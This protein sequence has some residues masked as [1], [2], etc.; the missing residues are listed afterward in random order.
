MRGLPAIVN[1]VVTRLV[2]GYVGLSIATGFA[3]LPSPHAFM[4]ENAPDGIVRRVRACPF[5]DQD[6]DDATLTIRSIP[7]FVLSSV[8]A[9]N[10]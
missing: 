4:N 6:C 7:A 8:E 2:D 10:R 5:G 3:A 1:S 9:S